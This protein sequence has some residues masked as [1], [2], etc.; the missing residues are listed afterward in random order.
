MIALEGNSLNCHDMVALADAVARCGIS[1]LLLSRNQIANAGAASLA[2]ALKKAKSLTALDISSNDIGD[3]GIAELSALLPA[4]PHLASLNVS[5]N[6]FS[7]ASE[8]ALQAAAPPSL[9]LQA[10]PSPPLPDDSPKKKK[11]GRAAA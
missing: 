2:S 5:H 11:G 1:T 10:T 7:A 8:E 9:A 4:V 6:P 3:A